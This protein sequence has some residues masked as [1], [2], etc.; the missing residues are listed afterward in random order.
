MFGYLRTTLLPVDNQDTGPVAMSPNQVTALLAEMRLQDPYLQKFGAATHCYT[1]QPCL[2]QRR[3]DEFEKAIGTMIPE[4]YRD[5]LLRFGDGGAGP[6]YGLLS[7][8]NSLREFGPDPIQS[9]GRPFSPPASTSAMIEDRAY[10]EDGLLPL[11]HV[12]CGHMWML[13]VTGS[14]R[15]T[16]WSYQA[17]R[18]YEPESRELP[19]YS[20]AT[21][22]QQR[23]EANNRLTNALL[24]DPTRRLDFWDWYTDWIG[25]APGPAPLPRTAVS[26]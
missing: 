2:P 24:S 1:L 20:L 15:G 8:G 25:R 22:A 26:R 16:I 23:L 14:E 13:V 19:D 21:T 18:D 12:G 7:L 6:G 17:G 11:A 10:P 3:L 4:D 9:I 5:F